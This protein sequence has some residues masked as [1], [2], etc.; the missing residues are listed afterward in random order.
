M[1]SNLKTF[2]SSQTKPK[3]D[4]SFDQSSF[5]LKIIKGNSL[6]TPII[7]SA[8]FKAPELAHLPVKL[9]CSWFFQ[10]EGKNNMIEIPEYNEAFFHTTIDDV[11]GK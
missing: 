8:N 1:L 3:K 10:P 7:V 9:K 5:S 2:I 4:Q 11:N 6:M